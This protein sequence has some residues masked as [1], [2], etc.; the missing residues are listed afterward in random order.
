MASSL[1]NVVD[2]LAE[3]IHK[4]NADMYMILKNAK[5]M[6]LNSKIV[7]AVL[8]TQTLRMIYYNAIVYVTIKIT[9]KV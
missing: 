6:E 3:G 7:S 4:K 2:N 8:N 5:S 9:K 1:L